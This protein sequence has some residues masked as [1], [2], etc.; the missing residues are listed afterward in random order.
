MR[1]NPWPLLLIFLGYSPAKAQELTFPIRKDFAWGS[2]EKQVSKAE[3][4]E[5]IKETPDEFGYYRQE[6]TNYHSYNLDSLRLCLHFLDI[7]G[8]N[9]LDVIFDG[10]SGG[11]PR[12]IEI[13]INKGDG[14][15][16]VFSDMQAI[17][18]LEWRDNR[19]SKLYIFDWGCCDDYVDY[20]KI[21]QTVFD[22]T[23]VPDLV[24]IHQEASIHFGEKPDTLLEKPT[25]FVVLN[26]NYNIRFAPIID[27]TSGQIW[28]DERNRQFHGNIIGK[29]SKGAK[30][31]ALGKKT[32]SSG[33]EWWYVEIDE[34]YFPVGFAFTK[35]NEKYPTKVI[36]WISSRFVTEF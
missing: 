4:D 35:E 18:K 30:G 27:D 24:Q 5:F 33:R 26:N 1:I 19:L 23:N 15:K 36:G 11:E 10:Q 29:L 6:V 20:G 32:D 13:F 34:E 22:K 7:N 2:V 8:D 14:Y 25:R 3:I 21:Y 9:L 16:K 28:D 12:E 31:H 17:S